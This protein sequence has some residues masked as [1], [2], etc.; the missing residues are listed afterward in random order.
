MFIIVNHVMIIYYIQTTFLTVISPSIHPPVLNSLHAE[1]KVR[2]FGEDLRW[3]EGTRRRRTFGFLGY[4]NFHGVSMGIM[5]MIY[6]WC[7]GLF[8]DIT[9]YFSDVLAFNYQHT[10]IS[11]I[12]HK[13]WLMIHLGICWV[14]DMLNFPNGKSIGIH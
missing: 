12:P 13:W 11:V 4:V 14:D 3:D 9:N 10:G 8:G 1:F 7:L 6:Q 5:N 2:R